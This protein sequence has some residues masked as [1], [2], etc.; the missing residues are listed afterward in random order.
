[1]LLVLV[2]LNLT[3]LSLMIPGL[4][5]EFTLISAVVVGSMPVVVL[6]AMFGEPI[7]GLTGDTD[8]GVVGRLSATVAGPAFFSPTSLETMFPSFA[9][10]VSCAMSVKAFCFS[11]IGAGECIGV[12]LEVLRASSGAV[13]VL[14]SGETVLDASEAMV[15]L[16]SET[17]REVL[18]VRSVV[19][20]I[21]RSGEA[22]IS[23]GMDDGVCN[24]V[25]VGGKS[26]KET[27]GGQGI[28][29][30]FV[31]SLA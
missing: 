19:V 21:L 24:E 2:G 22:S 4:G 14:R 11:V 18:I 16:I 12:T 29:R 27:G 30:F 7:D 23:V 6:S 9:V 31:V 1:M 17:L 13:L 3:V 10:E 28:Y 8:L 5:L 20:W 15:L 26:W 25:E